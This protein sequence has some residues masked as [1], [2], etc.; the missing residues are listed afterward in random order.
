MSGYKPADKTWEEVAYEFSWKY[1]DKVREI[2]SSETHFLEELQR[3]ELE[4]SA[5]KLAADS[6]RQQVSSEKARVRFYQRL[7]G[8]SAAGIG[9]EGLLKQ[10]EDLENRLKH[11]EQK[12]D[13][14]LQA[15]KQADP[16][17]FS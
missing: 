7:S 10:I 11:A 6:F 15:W 3:M 5:Q 2:E 17:A 1:D 9:E 16:K 8:Y 12:A 14:H 4:V 13:V